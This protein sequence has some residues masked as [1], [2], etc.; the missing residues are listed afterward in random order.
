LLF[1]KH[2]FIAA[3]TVWQRLAVIRGLYRGAAADVATNSGPGRGS[4]LTAAAGPVA[5]VAGPM[6][7][8]NV[9]GVQRERNGE[10][11]HD[12]VVARHDAVVARSARTAA[13]VA[14]M[15]R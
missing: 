8:P 12:A 4:A 10:R 5:V 9:V 11:E 6:A 7:R 1:A 2:L 3:R 14:T 13:A 15:A